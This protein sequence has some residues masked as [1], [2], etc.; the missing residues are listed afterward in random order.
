MFSFHSLQLTFACPDLSQFEKY[1]K[2]I[3]IE[4][5]FFTICYDDK[6]K[7]RHSHPLNFVFGWENCTGLI[8]EVWN[9]TCPN[10]TLRNTKSLYFTW[11]YNR[12]SMF[13]SS[14]VKKSLLDRKYV[15]FH[16]WYGSNKDFKI[17]IHATLLSY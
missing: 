8:F 1:D 13:Q 14:Y 17:V 15:D 12:N 2:E 16:K 9:D 4:N 6:L 11:Y 5:P 10:V 3:Q 7:E